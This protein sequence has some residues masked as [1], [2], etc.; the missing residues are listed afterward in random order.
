[1]SSR[2]R[3]T[4]DVSAEKEKKIDFQAVKKKLCFA[5]LLK[6]EAHLLLFGI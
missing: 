4:A 6:S 5:C 1:M 3:F 2:L